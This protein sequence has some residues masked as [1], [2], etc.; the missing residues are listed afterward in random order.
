MLSNTTTAADESAARAPAWAAV[1]SMTLGAFSLVAAEFLPASLLTPI[2]ADLSI[3]EGAAGQ[4]VTMTAV[5]GFLAGLLIATAAR[6]AD[7][8][9]L[10]MGFSLA[11]IVSNLLVAFAPSLPLLLLGRMLLGVALG[12][13]WALSTAVTMRLVPPALVPKAI[14]VLMSGVS[15]ATVFAAP[16]G[17]FLGDIVG[18]RGVFLLASLLGLVAFAMQWRSLPSM[19]PASSAKLSTMVEVLMRPGTG[20]GMVAVLLVFAGH[21]I[22]F[23]YLRAYLETGSG[24]T[25]EAI[26]SILLGFGIAN[27]LGTF[28]AGRMVAKSLRLTLVLV[29]LLMG[30]LGLVMVGI[31]AS[32]LTDIVGTV[33]WGML[34]G[35]IPVAWSSWIARSIPD[36]AESAGG[37]FVASIQLAIA[38]G[39]GFGGLIFDL[40]GGTGTIAASGAVLLLAAV[41]IMLGVRT[42]EPVAAAA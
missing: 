3:S 36:E 14:A 42:R 18:W 34:F 10:L 35:G 28:L 37:L 11:L 39:A 31:G 30:T 33:L 22:F 21:F 25:V 19:R 4:A 20:L 12:S 13:F 23:T 41:S 32:P 15:A 17:S 7:R 27:F 1:A 8:R 38:L 2:A 26:S 5:F 29:P 9:H 24:F 16:L 6:T 40:A